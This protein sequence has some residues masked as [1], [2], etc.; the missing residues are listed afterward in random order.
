MRPK[1]MKKSHFLWVI[2]L[3]LSLGKIAVA[4]GGSV[5]N[6]TVPY[7]SYT[8]DF[9]GNAVPAPQAYLPMHKITG[10]D[11]G[12]GSFREANDFHV[13]S[14][15]NIYIAD[16][17][18]HRVIMF[19]SDWQF[20][21]EIKTF[22]LDGTEHTFAQ[23]HGIYVT[24]DESL[25]VA[26]TGNA[27]I[28]QFD[29]QG[30]ATR[31]IGEPK[32]DLEGAFPVGF[33]YR[34]LKVAVDG[35]GRMYVISQDLAEGFLSFSENGQFRGFVGAPR[36]TPDLIDYIWSRI[37][38]GEQR[39]RLQIFLPTEYTNLALDKEGY[40]YATV[41]DDDDGE[42]RD[43]VVRLN[44]RGENLLKK[45]GFHP[46]RGDIQHAS[47]WSKA[48]R[49]GQSTFVDVTVHDNGTY[50][51]LDSKRARVFTYDKNDNLLFVFGYRGTMHGQVENAAALD[52]IGETMLILDSRQNAIFTY[53]PTDYALLIWAA[54][55][56]YDRGDY[57]MTEAI[58]HKVLELN[59]N[60]DQ[61]YSGIGDALLRRGEYADAMYYFKLG[62]D[63]N[64]YS[65]AFELYRRGV[66]YDNFTMVS[67]IAAALLIVLVVYRLVRRKT[68]T[69]ASEPAAIV[70]NGKAISLNR[71]R[72]LLD[73]AWDQI[74]FVW[75][76]CL[77][78]LEG[79][80]KMKYEKKGNLGTA[81]LI[82]AMASGT[83][84][85]SRQY[86]GF[87]FNTADLTRLNVPMEIA[88]IVVP[89][90]LWC[91]INWSL[92]TLMDGKGTFRDVTI[93][94]AYALVPLIITMIPLTVVSN[95]LI[96]RE[97][98]F[99]LLGISLGTMWTLILLVF[100][101][102]MTIHEYNFSKTVWTC[103]FT[104][105]GMAFALFLGFLFFNLSEQVYMFFNEVISEII[106]RT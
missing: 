28:V 92:T 80:W 13:S 44:A 93:S 35:I 50:S 94:S 91:G 90:F 24:D 31:I 98:A 8:F 23:P 7:T 88:S 25:Y 79:F 4:T 70:E 104:A 82:L 106:F 15:G 40:I 96:Q 83:F 51:V 21:R 18:N 33:T 66:I 89:F 45:A 37:A 68:K 103:I 85:F 41:Y 54:L 76:I 62:N 81:M 67:I 26:D 57:Q 102:V 32:S 17:G 100:G 64:G 27:R 72:R 55:D 1:I 105:A 12:V 95:Y 38:T 3:V 69:A 63:R 43:K 53:E 84:I 46:P 77:H 71:V 16:T 22:S 61:A 6:F 5:S 73:R 101:A 42:D 2:V 9:W 39:E 58:W 36:V 78:P 10:E 75:Y 20:V 19:D 29:S 47:R 48:T 59:A 87:V 49:K 11:L 30:V 65:K 34:P 52:N 14:A 99:Y 97:G 74:R 86:T 60:F 56:A